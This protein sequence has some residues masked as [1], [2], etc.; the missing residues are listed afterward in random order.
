MHRVSEIRKNSFRSGLREVEKGR[1]VFLLGWLAG[2]LAMCWVSN[3]VK[4]SRL[5]FIFFVC[6]MNVDRDYLGM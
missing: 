5:F 4:V 3:K 2:W 1:F 6:E